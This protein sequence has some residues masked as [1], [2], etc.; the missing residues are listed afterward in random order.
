MTRT[1]SS[2]VLVHPT[3]RLQP[4]SLIGAT[5]D[6][7][8]VHGRPESGGPSRHRARRVTLALGE[9][10]EALGCVV[11]AQSAGRAL[12]WGPAFGARPADCGGDVARAELHRPRERVDE[13]DVWCA[14]F[15][16]GQ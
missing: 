7:D 5:P 9:P 16:G 8:P 2:Q 15:S 10:V 3:Y 11:E 13:E 4:L 14:R 1:G 6:Q 12:F